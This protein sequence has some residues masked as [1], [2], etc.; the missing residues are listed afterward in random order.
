MS[1]VAVLVLGAAVCALAI[2]GLCAAARRTRAPVAEAGIAA[3]PGAVAAER[4]PSGRYPTS[5][6]RILI[7][8]DEPRVGEMIA[9]LMTAHEVTTVTSGEAALA[10]LA[11][12]DQFD[13]ILCDLIMPG[14]SGVELAEV[15][16]ERHRAVRPRMVFLTSYPSTPAAKQFLT[17]SEARWLTK[18]VRYAQLATCVS[19]VVAADRAAT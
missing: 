13:A 9:R 10:T 16:A 8:D 12:D 6:L 7:V 5:R 3:E 18:P 17:R 19:E 14:M 4:S 15:V 1:L 11:T 2:L